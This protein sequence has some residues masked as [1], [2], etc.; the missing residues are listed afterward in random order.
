MPAVEKIMKFPQQ[1]EGSL[2]DAFGLLLSVEDYRKAMNELTSFSFS[3]RNLRDGT[4]DSMTM[5]AVYVFD[6]SEVATVT[7]SILKGCIEI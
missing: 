4:A 1:T 2:T 6:R 3:A 5:L 7:R